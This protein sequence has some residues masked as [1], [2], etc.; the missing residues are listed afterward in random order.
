MLALCVLQVQ[1]TVA[2]TQTENLQEEMERIKL[3]LNVPG[4]ARDCA[5]SFNWGT[6]LLISQSRGESDLW[7]NILLNE[8]QAPDKAYLE[9]APVT[10]I[11]LK[12]W[13]QA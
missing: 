8:V 1:R 10:A 2:Q 12:A 9:N 11:Y 4:N 13:S 7:V 5:Q 3:W 6:A